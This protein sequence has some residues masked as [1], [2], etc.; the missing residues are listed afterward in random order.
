MAVDLIMMTIKAAWTCDHCRHQ[1]I[2][3]YTFSDLQDF[4]DKTDDIH[5]F[6]P[7]GWNGEQDDPKHFCNKCWMAYNI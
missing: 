2:K 1:E 7:E 6:L 3:E 4:D 5:R